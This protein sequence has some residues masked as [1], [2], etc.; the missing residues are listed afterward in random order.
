LFRIVHL[1][2]DGA[3]ANAA[4]EA[5]TAPVFRLSP[6]LKAEIEINGADVIE[7][8]REN[9][10]DEPAVAA[11]WADIKRIVAP[12]DADV[13]DVGAASREPFDG[14]FGKPA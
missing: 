1:R 10:D 14:L 7:V 13:D 9:G 6:A 11:M 5:L 8:R 12:F 3:R 4:A 2:R